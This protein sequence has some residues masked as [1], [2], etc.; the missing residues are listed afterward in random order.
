M[1]LTG[2]RKKSVSYREKPMD[3]S[4][5]LQQQAGY[6]AYEFLDGRLTRPEA[7]KLLRIAE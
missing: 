4:F 2:K 1:I 6:L 5:F 7:V 3:P